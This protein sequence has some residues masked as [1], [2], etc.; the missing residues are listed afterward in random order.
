[1]RLW[2]ANGFHGRCRITHAGCGD[3]RPRRQPSSIPIVNCRAIPSS[4]ASA[5]ACGSARKACRNPDRSRVHHAC[6]VVGAGRRCVARTRTDRELAAQA[7]AAIRAEMRKNIAAQDKLR[8][9]VKTVVDNLKAV[10]GSTS[11]QTSSISVNPSQALLSEAAP[12]LRRTRFSTSTIDA[13]CA[14]PRCTNCR[15]SCCMRNR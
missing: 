1:M 8:A 9:R 2:S 6:A 13:R 11:A 4:Q 15:G 12:R 3:S 7:R 5:P 14:S 10:A